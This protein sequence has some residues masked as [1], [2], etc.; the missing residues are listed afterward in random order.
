MPAAHTAGWVSDLSVVLCSHKFCKFILPSFFFYTVEHLAYCRDVS[1]VR[2]LI[3]A[4]CV[5]QW[6]NHPTGSGF[7]LRYFSKGWEKLFSMPE[8]CCAFCAAYCRVAAEEKPLGYAMEQ[9]RSSLFTTR[10]CD[11]LLLGLS[12]EKTWQPPWVK[13]E[14]LLGGLGENEGREDIHSKGKEFSFQV[15]VK[16]AR[17]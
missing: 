9:K 12:L 7:P 2:P 10:T 8:A 3:G 11:S 17:G 13:G 6:P 14:F 16:G 4:F 5:S 15:P 1:K